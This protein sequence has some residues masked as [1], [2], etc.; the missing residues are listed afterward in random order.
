MTVNSGTS[1]VDVSII[2][3][4]Y[5]TREM[6]LECLRS[7][8]AETTSSFELIVVD[9]ASSDGS[10]EAIAKEFPSVHLMA[11]TDNHGFAKGNN[12]A[13]EHAQGKYILLLNPDTVVLDGAI[14]KLLAFA[15]DRPEAKVWGGKTLFGDRSLNP[16]SCF[17]Q[18]TVW[19]IF[20]RTTGLAAVFRGSS[21]FNPEDYG[22]WPRDTIREVDIICGCYLMTRREFWAELGGFDLQFVMYGEDADLCMRAKA[23]DA[24]PAITPDSTI[25]HYVGA[26]QSV[27]AEKTVRLLS[28]KALI[29]RRHFPKSKQGLGLFLL[30]L[31]PLTRWIALASVALVTRSEH[32]RNNADQ[33]RAVWK[34]R[35]EWRNGWPSPAA[36]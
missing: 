33:W 10:A 7:V 18:M 34:R 25:V 17:S 22:S 20:C 9:N 2:V 15:G 19:S 27:R 31:W 8:Y 13:A 23:L 6:T 11:E 29:V 35:Q 30:Q 26:S 21:F 14:D 32:H 36:G 12:I 1:T 24:K 28:G 5:N 4:S 3:V 16:M